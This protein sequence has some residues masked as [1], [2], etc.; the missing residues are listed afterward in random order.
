MYLCRAVFVQICANIQ[1]RTLLRAALRLHAA[2]REILKALQ[3][4][5][6]LTCT[7]RAFGFARRAHRCYS[8]VFDP[9]KNHVAQRCII[10]RHPVCRR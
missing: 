3:P 9:V 8:A 6:P 10:H 1:A 5:A 7:R 2:L 4:A